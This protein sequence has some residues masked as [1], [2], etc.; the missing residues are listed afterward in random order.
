M[1]LTW[2]SLRRAPSMITPPVNRNVAQT[3]LSISE[4]EL[5]ADLEE[6]RIQDGRR[7]QPRRVVG[8]DRSDGIAVEDVVDIE[9]SPDDFCAE[10]EGFGDPQIELVQ[11]LTIHGPGRH[12]IER[13]VCRAARKVAPERWRDDGCGR[14]VIRRTERTRQALVRGREV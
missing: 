5:P 1:V 4:V 2:A 7:R 12:Q 3:C 14:A 11:P 8:V 13:D 6:T 9:V 10:P